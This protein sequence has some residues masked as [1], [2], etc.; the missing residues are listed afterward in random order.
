LRPF[1][2]L[3]TGYL[4]DGIGGRETIAVVAAWTLAIAVLSTLSPA[5]RRPPQVAAAA[6]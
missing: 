2:L 1:G 5:L 6:R 4:L 3:V